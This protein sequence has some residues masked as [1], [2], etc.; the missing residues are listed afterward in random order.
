MDSLANKCI[1][2]IL[3]EMPADLETLNW[4]KDQLAQI[5]SLPFSIKPSLAGEKEIFGAQLQIGNKQKLLK[6]LSDENMD[7]PA[8]KQ[9]I[10]RIRDG[11]EWFFAKTRD[12]WNNYMAAVQTA[13]DMP[14]PQAYSELEKLAENMEKEA[15]ENPDASLAGLLIP[16][17]QK[18]YSVQIKAKTSSN[19]TKAAMEVYIIKA[20]TGKL[21]VTLPDN[22]PMDLFS[23]KPFEY[24]KTDAGFVLSCQGKD[25]LKN[26]THEYEFKIKK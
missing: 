13:M 5:D 4:L 22:L 18:I 10:D 23:D 15:A 21:P 16:A 11:N 6:L 19:A 24:E 9:M 25:L 26:K 20:K 14:Y 7:T 3:A 1:R 8:S 12:Y 17:C 2:V